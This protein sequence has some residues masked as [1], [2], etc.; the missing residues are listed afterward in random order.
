MLYRC[1]L[2]LFFVITVACGGGDDIVSVSQDSLAD[3]Q[4]AISEEKANRNNSITQVLEEVTQT[5]S[6]S[7]PEE[8]NL[9]SSIIIASCL[10]DCAVSS[11]EV[12]CSIIDSKFTSAYFDEIELFD[13]AGYNI[14]KSNL[15]FV[16]DDEQLRVSYPVEYQVANM[17]IGL[18]DVPLTSFIAATQPLPPPPVLDPIISSFSV[19]GSST[20]PVLVRKDSIQTVEWISDYTDSCEIISNNMIIKDQLS[21]SGQSEV[22]ISS[23]TTLAIRCK[24]SNGGIASESL[25]VSAVLDPII[26]SL[27]VGDSQER[28]VVVETGT[29]H[30]LAWSSENAE[31]CSLMIE[32][33][34]LSDELSGS[35]DLRFNVE[36]PV[37]LTCQNSLG[38]TTRAE[39]TIL[40]FSA[41]VICEL[42]PGFMW[43]DA[44]ELCIEDSVQLGVTINRLDLSPRVTLLNSQNDTFSQ[45]IMIPS[46]SYV[47]YFDLYTDWF[48]KRPTIVR[49]YKSVNGAKGDLI[50]EQSF[51][52]RDDLVCGENYDATCT[53]V[54]QARLTVEV[55]PLMLLEEEGVIFETDGFLDGETVLI[56]G[57]GVRN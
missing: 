10:A 52:V 21:P 38:V 18:S 13:S 14:Q 17:K 35:L 19:A 29:I 48:D 28:S 50:A 23:D 27:S 31:K 7:E 2:K 37:S 6:L 33:F 49:V 5:S 54:D 46:G 53:D 57:I 51:A 15:G 39:I 32:N 16:I 8:L 1:C 4:D 42:E 36:S 34:V 12:T 11:S 9:P 40:P 25:E 22:T 56:F 30:P 41:K 45:E 26:T 44:D 24:N 3:S 20:A 55:Q 43:L 47:R